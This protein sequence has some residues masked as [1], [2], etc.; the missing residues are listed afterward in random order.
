MQRL[1]QLQLSI[2]ICLILAS[3]STDS[4][5]FNTKYM[6]ESKDVRD[7]NSAFD[8][9]DA[10]NLDSGGQ[11]DLERRDLDATSDLVD[12]D[13]LQE[14]MLFEEDQGIPLR[15]GYELCDCDIEE[16][17]ECS[18]NTCSVRGSCG[19]QHS[20]PDGFFCLE[21]FQRCACDSSQRDCRPSCMSDEDCP[22]HGRRPR[23]CDPS[24]HCE[25]RV[26]CLG[27]S[28]CRRG[29]WCISR[30]CYPAGEL[31]DRAA[32]ESSYEC[33]SGQCYGGF[34]RPRCYRDAD[35]L[36]TEECS[37][38]GNV[39][40]VFPR[41]CNVTCP[42]D[43]DCHDTQCI[44]PRCNQEGDCIEGSCFAPPRGNGGECR[45]SMYPPCKSYEFRVDA[46]EEDPYCRLP[47]VCSYDEDCTPPYTCESN[48]WEHQP[49]NKRLCSRLP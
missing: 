47:Q 13:Y 37:V 45:P 44:P 20:C 24:G 4:V 49:N 27:E 5:S 16:A 26:K 18:H 6:D 34:C 2:M 8:M 15:P 46:G 17:T 36:D 28:E 41:R 14:D 1:L 11:K 29:E 35:C 38:A 31:E 3:C 32:C 10:R 9:R 33:Q 40:T 42:E 12:S 7:A 30:H 25:Y 43:H 39:C 23:F 21:E 48:G 19:E 22:D